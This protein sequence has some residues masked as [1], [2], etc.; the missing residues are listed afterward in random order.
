MCRVALKGTLYKEEGTD[1]DSDEGRSGEELP[2]VPTQRCKHITIVGVSGSS[3]SSSSSS[4]S[5][6]SS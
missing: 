4:N 5:G 3:S 2:A 1:R 6:R